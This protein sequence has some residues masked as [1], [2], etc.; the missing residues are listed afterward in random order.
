MSEEPKTENATE[1]VPA[2][3]PAA[4]IPTPTP[5]GPEPAAEAPS[6]TPAEPVADASNETPA[7]PVADASNAQ[8]AE[9]PATEPAQ[10]AAAPPTEGADDVAATSKA[11]PGTSE[12]AEKKKKP[13]P[14]SSLPQAL[15]SS[16]YR[17]FRAGLPIEG[18]VE[19]VIKGGYEVKL[20][21]VR[22]FC[23]HSQV[24]V[25]RVTEAESKVGQTLE[26]RITQI[27]RGGDDIVVSRRALLDEERQENAKAVRATLVEGT[28][29]RGRITGVAA[30]GAFVDLGAG[31]KGLVHVSELSH[32]RAAK[33]EDIVKVGDDVQVKV[34]KVDEGRGR[35]SLSMRQATEDPWK[36]VA[37]KFDVGKSYPGKVERITD[38]GAFVRLAPDLEG[39]APASEFPPARL[40]W[41]DGL[42]VG[43][44][45]EWLVLSVDPG[46]RRISLTL[47][48][49]GE[50]LAADAP[51]ETG[52]KLK[53]RVQR[54]ERFGVFVWL[55][56]GRV[57][58]MPREF[59]GAPRDADLTR[60]FAGGDEVEVEVVG[61]EEGGRRIRLAKPGFEA[62]P[63]ARRDSKPRID[64]PS[65]SN[66]DSGRGGHVD[67]G[68]FGTSLA[69]KLRAALGD[70]KKD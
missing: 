26:F 48:S 35:I 14:R 43:Q 8:P 42:E 2:A 53:G 60:R 37:E 50:A 3:E 41:K 20:G 16:L 24:D 5:A 61:I 67:P 46:K 13:G 59:I 6:E 28:V 38:F 66:R 29:M 56:P 23:P 39:L 63:Q 57:G 40:G 17:S 32:S 30:F 7:E 34:L 62:R 25:E 47:P 51:L 18:K 4:E 70:E 33:A 15:R 22:A 68:N 11:E 31:V 44:E 58:L 12:P 65:R 45:K 54:I 64:D 10:E 55:G 27:R 52:A 21:K 1:A 19:K 69:E 9:A 49:E 36:G